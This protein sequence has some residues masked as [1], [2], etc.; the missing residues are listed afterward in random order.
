MLYLPDEDIDSGMSESESEA[1][2]N[3]LIE[4]I[5]EDAIPFGNLAVLNENFPDTGEAFC[6]VLRTTANEDSEGSTDEGVEGDSGTTE[7]GGGGLS[8]LTG[9]FDNMT[10]SAT[11]FSSIT[12]MPT[13]AKLHVEVGTCVAIDRKFLPNMEESDLPDTTLTYSR[14]SDNM[15][16]KDTENGYEYIIISKNG[17]L[18]TYCKCAS[19]AIATQPTKT[20][21]KKGEYFDPTGMKVTATCQDGTTKDV[22]DKVTCGFTTSAFSNTST[23]EVTVTFREAGNDYTATVAVTVSE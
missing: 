13:T 20:A 10:M 6:V 5:G 15:M 4:T 16:I 1:L 2:L 12:D 9:L 17:I 23:K 7:E 21:Y 18:E 14:S 3:L 22:T 8:G 11:I 19:I